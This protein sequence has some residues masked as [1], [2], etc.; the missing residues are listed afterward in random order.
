MSFFENISNSANKGTEASKEYVSKSL[1]YSKLKAF[2]L[3]TLSIGMLTKL[4][5]IGSLVSLGFVF[6]AFSAAIALGEYFQNVA[7]GYLSV[8]L[9]LLFISLL[10]Y[11]F[12]KFLDKKIITKMT[13]I[14]FD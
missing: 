1:E 7:L 3:T 9:F 8:G 6:V 2:Q 4:F 13:K 14:F 5:I 10:I 12:R 11:L